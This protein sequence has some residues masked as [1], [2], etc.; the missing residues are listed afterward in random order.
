MRKDPKYQPINNNQ[1]T[2]GDNTNNRINQNEERNRGR[3]VCWT[4]NEEGHFSRYCAKEVINCFACRRQGNVKR[5][6]P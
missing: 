2:R 3:V 5:N 1:K 6:C 4:C